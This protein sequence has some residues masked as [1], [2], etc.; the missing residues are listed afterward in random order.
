MSLLGRSSLTSGL[1]TRFV[2]CSRIVLFLVLTVGFSVPAS[3]EEKVGH[4]YLVNYTKGEDR[5][6]GEGLIKQP[7]FEAYT[8]Y[9]DQ[10]FHQDFL[11]AE[12]G[13]VDYEQADNILLLVR[14]S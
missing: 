9:L 14:A 11:V 5:Q 2:S 7:G 8:Y 6:D 4:V 10:L 1:G 13:F 12:G 3:A